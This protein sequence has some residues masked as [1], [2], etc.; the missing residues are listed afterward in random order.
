MKPFE[1]PLPFRAAL[2]LRRQLRFLDERLSTT[3]LSSHRRKRMSRER[4]AY[5]YSLEL[6]AEQHPDEH[7]KA[8]KYD[9][10]L[11]GA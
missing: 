4:E 6:I 2:T 1:P 11:Q 7:A 9:Q 3:D 5:A 8:L 10:E